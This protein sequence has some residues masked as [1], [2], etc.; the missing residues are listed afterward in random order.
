ADGRQLDLDR[1]AGLQRVTDLD[2]N[3]LT[4]TTDGIIHSGGKSVTYTRDVQGRITQID[5][6]AGHHLSYAY[7]AAGDL[8]QVTDQQG[9]RTT[10]EYDSN[11]GL[12]SIHDPLGRQ[13]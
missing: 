10:F 11:H 6:P 1:F 5:D 12:L 9:K 3:T 13:A 4:F 8:A 7:T 2:G